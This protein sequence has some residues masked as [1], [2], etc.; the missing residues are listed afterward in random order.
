MLIYEHSLFEYLSDNGEKI[1][2]YLNWLIYV[3]TTFTIVY[4]YD[5]DWNVFLD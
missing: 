5:G 2:L 1:L 3:A 4:L